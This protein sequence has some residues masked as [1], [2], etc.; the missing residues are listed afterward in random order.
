MKPVKLTNEQIG[1][2]CTAL[3]HLIHAGIGL[4]DALVLLAEDEKELRLGGLLQ[5][6]AKAADGGA[7]LADAM[8]QSGAFPS[9]VC[10]LTRVGEQVG[11]IE[12]TL[13]AL[14]RHYE[15]RSRMDRQLQTA[16]LYPAVLLAVLLAVTV[17]L[18]V[19]VL[20]VFNEVY[21]QLGSSLTGL[22]G[23][24]L[25]LGGWIKKALPVLCG[26]LGIFVFILAIA[27]LRRQVIGLLSRLQG[28]RGVERKIL[29]A[30]FV[31]ALSMALSSGM[32]AQEAAYLASRL[33][34]GQA[35]AFCKRCGEFVSLLEKGESLSQALHG[36]DF[37]SGAERRLLDA[38]IRSGKGEDMLQKISAGL[39]EQSEEALLRRSGRIEPALVS[40]ACLLIG[41]VLLSVMLPLMHIMNAIG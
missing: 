18:L 28:D 22:A 41:A 40:I 29:S 2:F 17:V 23:G 19:W 8:E 6:M 14:A 12:Q 33:S 9:Y 26:I 39:L 15:N 34:E 32:A 36:C 24:L 35:S 31:Q 10:T 37:I 38:A 7:T 20:P 27:P 16:L 30:R 11:R 13:S 1:S 25:A 3:E 21:A 5:S 4:G